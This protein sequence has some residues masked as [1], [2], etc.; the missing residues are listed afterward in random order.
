MKIADNMEILSPNLQ[1]T[2]SAKER[3]AGKGGP[4]EALSRD[5]VTV[6]EGAKEIARLQ[7]EVSRVPEIRADRVEEIQNAINAGIYNV[8]GEAV[9][10]KLLTE[11][12]IDSLV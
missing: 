10:G 6:S 12:I 1:R 8:R 11:A 3:T 2:D 4:E 9:A 7:L 5:Q